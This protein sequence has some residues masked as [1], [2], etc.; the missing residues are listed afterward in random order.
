MNIDRLPPEAADD[1]A[2]MSAISD[3]INRV[4]KVAEDGLWTDGAARTSPAEVAELTRAGEI[5]VA[6]MA[7]RLAGSVRVRSATSSASSA[8]SSPRRRTAAP[9][10]AASWCGSPSG[11][12]G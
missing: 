2:T 11:R 4:Y 9:G 10:W 6:R 5:V 8:C 7:G 3:L 1:G 12:A